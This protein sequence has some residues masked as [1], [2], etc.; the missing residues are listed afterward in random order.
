VDVVTGKVAVYHQRRQ[1][2]RTDGVILTPNQRVTFYEQEAHF[3][4]GLVD[5]PKMIPVPKE[6]RKPVSFHYNDTPLSDVIH[7]LEQAYGIAIEVENEALTNCQLT[8]NLNDQPL[9]TQLDL[10]CAA[11]HMEYE[12][13]GTTIL[14]SG[15]GCQE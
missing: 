4:T 3:V 14:F 13:R 10:I 6:T 5:A 1:A 11:L 12:V 2:D 8:A 15:K 9:F 7:H